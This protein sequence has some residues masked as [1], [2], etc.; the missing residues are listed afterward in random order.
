MRNLLNQFT[1]FFQTD[2]DFQREI[3]NLE[4]AIK[5]PEW[6]FY[7]KMLMMIK[8]MMATNMFSRQY[9]DLSA[10]EK[11]VTQRTYYNIGQ[12]LTFLL[13]PLVWIKKKSKWQPKTNLKRKEK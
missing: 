7:V 4:I 1:H 6:K 12:M 13:D 11:D 8:G 9:T 3:G 2:E 5:S 10:V